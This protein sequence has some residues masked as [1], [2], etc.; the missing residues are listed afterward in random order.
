MPVDINGKRVIDSSINELT[1]IANDYYDHF[2]ASLQ[3]DFN[4]NMNFNKNEVTADIVISSLKAAGIPPEKLTPQLVDAFR[5]EFFM[6]GIVNTSN[7]LTSS[8]DKIKEVEFKNEVLNEHSIL[9]KE[10]FAEYMVKK[11]TNKITI[12]N[13][14]N[15]PPENQMHGYVGEEEF[16]KLFMSMSEKLK[17][18]S[19][20]KYNLDKE[21][22]IEECAEMI[23]SYLSRVRIKNE[24]EIESGKAGF[25][26]AQRF[27]MADAEKTTIENFSNIGLEERSDFEIVNYIMYHTMLPR[28]AILKVLKRIERRELLN[29]QEILDQVTHQILDFFNKKKSDGVKA[30]EIIEGYELDETRIFELDPIDEDVLREEKAVYITDPEKRKA[31]NQYYRMD[32]A[33]EWEFARALENNPN[34]KMFTKL[35]KDGFVIETPIGNYSPDWAIVYKEN[36]ELNLYFIVE[37][38][39][40]KTCNQLMPEEEIKIKCGKLH[41][42]AVT[43]LSSDRIQFDW[44]SSYSDFKS[45]FGVK[46]SI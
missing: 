4:D 31:L 44:A 39:A 16:Y 41:F 29:D 38:K 14:D 30:Y 40:N 6:N 27:K 25:D 15:E 24:Y 36:N 33:G 28:F 10:K 17:K 21:R 9:I 5:Q 23:N 37:T 20:Y 18:R 42:N 13:G 22:F 8:A 7:M 1:V 34:I 26:E 35:K 43:K 32:S 12:K 46:D 19:I 11:G 45:K 3:K 2:E